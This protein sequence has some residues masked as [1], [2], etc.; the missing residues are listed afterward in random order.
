ML[1]GR[2]APWIRDAEANDPRFSG[3][4]LNAVERDVSGHRTYS[5]ARINAYR[6]LIG[7]RR[8]K[9]DGART[10]RCAVSNFKG[11][12]GKTTTAVHLAQKCALEGYRVLMIDLDP[13]ATTTLLFGLTADLEIR[14]EQ[15]IGDC[16]VENPGEVS[17]VIMRSYFTGIDLI[18]ANLGLQDAE[19]LLANP[20][21]NL[22]RDIGLNSIERLK[23][24]L[25]SVEDDYDIVVMDCGPNL[26]MLTLN[27]I[28]AA[29]GLLIPMQAMM[30]DFGSAILYLESMAALMAN[31]RFGHPL[32][33]LRVVI[34]RHTGSAEARKAEAMIRHSFD[35]YVLTPYTLQTVEVERASNDVGS[36]Y[37]IQ[38]TRG[39]PEAYRRA[40]SSFDDVNNAMIEV[41]E[42]VWAA[43]VGRQ[44]A[45]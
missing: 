40:L 44:E 39:S 28:H 14:P 15:T 41:F 1:I 33:F 4:P 10:I 37:D 36:I 22:E 25:D 42:G 16:L 29:S 32:E 26:G 6:D 7:T 17:S 23:A 27:A 20:S 43:Q 45:V 18:P 5:L 24:A 31:P 11:G 13:Q 19:M 8:R 30:P 35:P 12:A 9:P 34:T 38:K 2:S 3:P 21:A